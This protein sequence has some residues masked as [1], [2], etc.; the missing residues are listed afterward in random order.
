MKKVLFL[1]MFAGFLGSLHSQNLSNR[2]KSDKLMQIANPLMN[3]REVKIHFDTLVIVALSEELFYPFGKYVSVN[4]FVQK[5]KIEWYRSSERHDFSDTLDITVH[6][7]MRLDGSSLNFF[8]SVRTGYLDFIDGDITDKTLVFSN[9]M[10]VGMPKQTVL[11]KYFNNPPRAY[12][13]D[14]KVVKIYSGLYEVSQTFSFDDEQ[15]AGIGLSSYYDY[16]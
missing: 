2:A 3:V 6:N 4:E 8:Q 15:V 14:V 16:Y 7:F 9:G 1:L 10:H 13:E 12:T 5:S 11:E